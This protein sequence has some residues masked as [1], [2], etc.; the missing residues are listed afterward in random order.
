MSLS[1]SSAASFVGSTTAAII[2]KI[3]LDYN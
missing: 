2:L 1:S 3:F